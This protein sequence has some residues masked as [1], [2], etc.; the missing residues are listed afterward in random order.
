MYLSIYLFES[1]RKQTRESTSVHVPARGGAE[2]QKTL[3]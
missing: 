3:C 1:E 2:G